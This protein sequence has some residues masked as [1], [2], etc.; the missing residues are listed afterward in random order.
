VVV[1][2]VAGFVREVI[3]RVNA[4]MTTPIFLRFT[5]IN[6]SFKFHLTDGFVSS[7]L[8]KTFCQSNPV[9]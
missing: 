9:A 4:A 1:S 2:A 6:Y 8:E 3:A 7:F 5:F